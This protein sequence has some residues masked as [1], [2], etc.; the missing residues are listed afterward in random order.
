MDNYHCSAV[1]S[2]RDECLG[3]RVSQ[4]HTRIFNLSKDKPWFHASHNPRKTWMDTVYILIGTSWTTF[5]AFM[6]ALTMVLTLLFALLFHCVCGDT[7]TFENAFDL[8]YHTFTTIGFGILY[9]RNT[10]ANYTAAVEVFFASLAKAALA[11]FVFAKF[12]MPVAPVAFAA[13]CVVHAYGR[14][15][16]ALVLRVCNT[17]RSPRLDHDAVLEASFEVNMLRI[18]QTSAVDRTLVL[19]RYRLQ[20]VQADFLALRKDLQLVHVIDATSP[21]AGLTPTTCAASDFYLQVQML[22]VDATSQNAMQAFKVY[23][24]EQVMWGMQF[25][26]MFTVEQVD[27]G[28][29]QATP[30]QLVMDYALLDDLVPAPIPPLLLHHHAPPP[31]LSLHLSDVHA[32]A[33]GLDPLRRRYMRRES[34][35]VDVV[36]QSFVEQRWRPTTTHDPPLYSLDEAV[37]LE[38]SFGSAASVAKVENAPLH[39][40]VKPIHIPLPRT[41]HGMYR[42][43]LNMSWRAIM[44]CNIV[45]FVVLI[46]VFALLYFAQMETV[47]AVPDVRANNSDLNLCVSYSVQTIMTIGFGSVGPDPTSSYQNFWVCVQGTLGIM[48]LTVFT[49]VAWAKFARPTAHIAFSNHALVTSIDGTRVLLVRAVNLRTHGRLSGNAFRLGVSETNTRTGLRQVHELPLVTA[50][51]ALI[52]IPAT[53]VHVID[54]DSPLAKFRTDADF[55]ACNL[56]MIALFSAVD[57]SFASGVFAR[58]V[59]RSKDFVV[60]A[61]FADCMDLTPHGVEIDFDRFHHWEQ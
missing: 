60:D 3:V 19:R 44:A 40:R 6:I 51:F 9:P 22:G 32:T 57:A 55:V 28:M 59:Y 5:S 34:S 37:D 11:G 29:G 26:D 56:Q 36:D 18:E 53:L 48:Y 47:Y 20:L 31:L 42:Q 35:M 10:C 30:Q 16:L 12:S 33:D 45:F 46:L 39:D 21:L 38:A 58:K 4:D 24:A 52:N 41:F 61:H 13:R 49:G 27:P 54:A 2:W 1:G 17:S 15:H 23:T 43:M 50:R 25:Q 8:S 7:D 14:H